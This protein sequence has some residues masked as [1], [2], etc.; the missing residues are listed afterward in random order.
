MMYTY[1]D[2]NLDFPVAGL[3]MF[4]RV[5]E[6]VWWFRWYNEHRCDMSIGGF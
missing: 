1:C 6:K 5:P 4:G 3:W 2:F